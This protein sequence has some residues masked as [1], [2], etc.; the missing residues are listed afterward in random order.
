MLLE[1]CLLEVSAVIL[2]LLT[3]KLSPEIDFV[4]LDDARDCSIEDN[5]GFSVVVTNSGA[6]REAAF[7]ASHCSFHGES[8]RHTRASILNVGTR[9]DSSVER[10]I[11]T[12]TT[13]MVESSKTAVAQK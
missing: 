7:L 4:E 5:E 2:K 13:V 8:I 10:I 12:V 3:F 6:V 9:E 1:L 11:I